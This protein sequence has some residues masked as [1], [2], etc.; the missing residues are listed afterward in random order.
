MQ[1]LQVDLNAEEEHL[2]HMLVRKMRNQPVEYKTGS[3]EWNLSRG[4]VTD[5]NK[6]YRIPVKQLVI[7]WALI[8]DDITCV[9]IDSNGALYGYIGK[10][11]MEDVVW[12]DGYNSW[13]DLSALKIDTEGVDWK[14]SLVERPK[15]TT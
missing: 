5:I 10:P 3:G 9:A 6:Q 12:V 7:P 8:R 1:N 2:C 15:Q 14:T 13:Y 11:T 4:M